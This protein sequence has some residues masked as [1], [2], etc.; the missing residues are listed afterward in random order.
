M[1]LC[2]FIS[3]KDFSILNCVEANSYSIAHNLDCGGKT[4]I[5]ISNNPHA[6]DEDF[7]ILK[8]G[9]EV[10]FK[11]IIDKIENNDDEKKYTVSCLEIEQIFNRQIILSDAEIIK[12]T[13]IEDFIVQTIKTYFSDSGDDF[14]DMSYINCSALTH[15]KVSAKPA[16]ENGVYNFKTYIGNTKQNYGIFIDFDFT[17]TSLNISVYKRDQ[18]FMQIDTT[19]TDIYSRKETYKVKVLAKLSVLWKNTATQEESMRYF[20]LHSDRT[21]SEVDTDR[22]DGTVSTIVIEAETEEEMIQDAKNE[23]KGNSYSHSIE[24]DIS[25]HSKI[26]PKDELYVGHEVLIKTAAAGIKESIIS[27][28][29]FNDDADAIS[30]KFGIL[31]VKLS[32]KLK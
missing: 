23:F 24:A 16:T 32:E 29:S 7:V 15:T 2:Y 14:V 17:N 11:G 10:K 26:Y 21:V 5:V 8:D 27:S 30:V 6:S 4:K 28:I 12:S 1:M 9:K 3:K 20:Y 18:S 22:I 25:A 13:G 19:T 31:K